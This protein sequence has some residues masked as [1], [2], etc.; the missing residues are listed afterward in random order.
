M[1][2]TLV[3]KGANFYENRLDHITYNVIHAESIALSTPTIEAGRIGQTYALRYTLTPADAED[4][5]LWTSSNQSVA[6]V[7]ENGV[8]T[9]VGC[10]ACTITATAGEASDVCAVTV[11]VTLDDVLLMKTW[12]AYPPNTTNDISTFSSY[13]PNTFDIMTAAALDPNEEK[14]LIDSNMTTGTQ[15]DATLK[16]VGSRPSSYTTFGWVV[17]LKLAANCSKVKITALDNTY[18]S[19][20]LFYKSTVPSALCGGI[21]I[22]SRKPTETWSGSDKANWPWTYSAAAEYNVPAGYDSVSV[23]WLADRENS[24]FSDFR[25]AT[26]EQLA[27][28]KIVCE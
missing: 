26:A 20:V 18:G 21:Y 4:P 27:A 17:P 3:I 11:E 19:C 23:T 12:K 9:I 7:S 28:F 13:A 15:A 24:P 8:V 25:E 10:G 16:P 2:K 5:V 6:T 1:S 14:L 22:A